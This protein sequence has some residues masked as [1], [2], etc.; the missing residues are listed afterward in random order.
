MVLHTRDA[1]A[2]DY[3]NLEDFPRLVPKDTSSHP[4]DNRFCREGT[5]CPQFWSSPKEWECLP[6]SGDA[7]PPVWNSIILSANVPGQYRPKDTSPPPCGHRPCREGTRCTL[8]WSSPKQWECLPT[9][10]DASP[11]AWN[12]T[13]LPVNAPGQYNP[14]D[15]NLPPCGHRPCPDGT[16]CAMI[17][18]CPNG[19]LGCVNQWGCYRLD[20]PR[21]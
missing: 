7:V 9:S 18:D 5:R 3:S 11:P 17:W 2:Q 19:A 14:K 10:R 21:S 20:N 13:N 12:P 8:L 1:S 15:T 4:C 16:R 6:I